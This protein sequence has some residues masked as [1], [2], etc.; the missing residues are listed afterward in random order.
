MSVTALAPAG[1][2]ASSPDRIIAICREATSLSS[3]MFVM[4]RTQQI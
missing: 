1:S 2:D 3:V 4:K